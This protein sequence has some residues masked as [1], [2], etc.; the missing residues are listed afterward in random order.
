MREVNTTRREPLL[1]GLAGPRRCRSPQRKEQHPTSQFQQLPPHQPL[2][3]GSING[4]S[5]IANPVISAPA[6]AEA[7]VGQEMKFPIEIDGTNGIP[8]SSRVVVKG[9]SPEPLHFWSCRAKLL[10]NK[11]DLSR[12]FTSVEALGRQHHRYLC[13][14]LRKHYSA[15]LVVPALKPNCGASDPDRFAGDT[16]Y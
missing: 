3:N 12:H 2:N 7:T 8:A 10:S 4:P 14:M 15:T 9:L 6:T 1:Q 16:T 5:P 13:V 11:P